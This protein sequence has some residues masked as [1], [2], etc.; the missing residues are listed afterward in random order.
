MT[1]EYDVS[2][3]QKAYESWALDQQ[4][5]RMAG[6]LQSLRPVINSEIQRYSG[7][8]PLLRGKAKTLAVSAVKNYDPTSGAKLSSWVVTNMQPLTR[9]SKEL[10]RPVH[11][12]E[13]AIRQGAELDTKRREYQDEHGSD[14]SSEEL[15]DYT[16]ISVKRI[17][18]VKRLVRPVVAESGLESQDEGGQDG[19]AFMGVDEVGTDPALKSSVEMV[20]SELNDRDKVIF[21]LK[22]GKRGPTIDN[23]SIAKRLGVSEGLVSQRSLDISNKILKAREYV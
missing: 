20:Y 5:E 19:G 13:L 17:G 3:P 18:D 14:P 16:G 4:P 8:K 9:Y 12:S 6:V 21:D 15:A 23:K 11:A 1:E 22:T 2:D 7:P 10:T